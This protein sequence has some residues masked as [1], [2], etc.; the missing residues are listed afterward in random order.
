[1]TALPG[2]ERKLMAMRIFEHQIGQYGLV[3]AGSDARDA[4]NAADEFFDMWE[5]E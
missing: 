2:D 1:M 4:I 5:G 3:G